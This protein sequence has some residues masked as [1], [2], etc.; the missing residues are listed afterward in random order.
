M[1]DNRMVW[2]GLAILCVILAIIIAFA[3]FLYTLATV[4][5]PAMVVAFFACVAM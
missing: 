2:K 4:G 3:L 5:H 1:T